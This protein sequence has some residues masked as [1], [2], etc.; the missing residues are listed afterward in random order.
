MCVQQYLPSKV[1]MVGE[2]LALLLFIPAY[3]TYAI[4]TPCCTL[5]DLRMEIEH[6]DYT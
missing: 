4:I 1:D 5:W 3:N 6:D 2:F